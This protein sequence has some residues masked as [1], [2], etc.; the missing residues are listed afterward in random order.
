M[1]VVD[2]VLADAVV[3]VAFLEDVVVVPAE[4][5]LSAMISCLLNSSIQIFYEDLGRLASNAASSHSK[6]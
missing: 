2:V 6:C 4:L 5:S 1:F 3:E